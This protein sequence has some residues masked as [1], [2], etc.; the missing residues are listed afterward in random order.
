MIYDLRFTIDAARLGAPVSNPA[1]FK[2][3]ADDFR[4]VRKIANR[5]S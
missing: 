4:K 3:T 5:K 1:R 2:M